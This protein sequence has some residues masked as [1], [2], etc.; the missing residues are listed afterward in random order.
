MAKIS[1]YVI[2]DKIADE[3]V[4]IGSAKTDGLFIRQN[5]PFMQR[6]NP[7]Y[8]NDLEVYRIGEYVES[9]KGLLSESPCLIPWDTYK[10]PEQNEGLLATAKV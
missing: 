4:V 8:L 6:Y 1:I 2:Y 9:S 10:A 3:T 7:N 5:L